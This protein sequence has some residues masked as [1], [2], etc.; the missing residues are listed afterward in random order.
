MVIGVKPFLGKNIFLP[1]ILNSVLYISVAP[2]FRVSVQKQQADQVLFSG[3]QKSLKI[4]PVSLQAAEI[5]FLSSHLGHFQTW[6]NLFQVKN[7]KGVF[8]ARKIQASQ[9]THEFHRGASDPGFPCRPI[10]NL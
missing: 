2:N 6:K 1:K 8:V 4:V 5:S 3:T 7:K 10:S 9:P